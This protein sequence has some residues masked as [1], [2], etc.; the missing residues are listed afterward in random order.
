MSSWK[1]QNCG[2]VNFAGIESCRRCQTSATGGHT[3]NQYEQGNFQVN[4]APQQGDWQTNK[5]AP[6]SNYQTGDLTLQF[7]QTSTDN[8]TQSNPDAP[9]TGY[10]QNPYGQGQPYSQGGNDYSSG[11]YA[12][13]NPYSQNTGYQHNTSYQPDNGYQQ[14]S[15]YAYNRGE[16]NN[17]N[18]PSQPYTSYPQ[19]DY[20]HAPSYGAPS[21]GGYQQSYSTGYYGQGAGV[22]R[23]G[24][25]LVMHKQAHLPDRCV[26]CNAPTN[27]EYLPRKLSWIHPAWILLIFASWIIYLIVYL[28]IRKK[29]D[30]AL[31]LCQQHTRNRQNGIIIGWASALFGIGFIILAVT[32]EQ[33]GF[34]FLAILLILFGAIFG[35]YAANVVSVSKMD[36]N[37]IW[38]KR[39]SQ[40][41]LANFPPTGRY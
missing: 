15:G 3:A 25:K 14:N 39:V 10:Q 8:F 2:L 12:N 9:D 17:L 36:D 40:D 30:V 20:S 1:C 13:N 34:V 23:E 32:A 33:P 16:T 19:T 7:P 35:A 6:P 41:Y 28:A 22:W 37:Y 11:G 38:I 26:K 18:N 27:N 24:D 5:S 29:A 21:M 31:G 4:R